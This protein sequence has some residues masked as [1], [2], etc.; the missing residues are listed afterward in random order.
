MSLKLAVLLADSNLDPNVASR[1]EVL[2]LAA[3]LEFWKDIV[4]EETGEVV[5]VPIDEITTKQSFK[6]QCDINKILERHSIK[7]VDSHQVIYPPE[8]Y[9]EFQNIDLVEAHAQ[10]GRAQGIFD[11]LP[12]EVR[13][14]FKNDALAFAAFA[15][16]P[17]N[18]DKLGELL[19]KIAEPGSYFPNPAQRGAQGAAAATAPLEKSGDA[20]A[21]AAS[22]SAQDGAQLAKASDSSSST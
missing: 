12:S 11:A 4:V 13:N 3:P 22:S 16:D 20:S 21:P 10:I 15:S 14:E 2:D 18:N 8:V 17:Q 19:P 5:K 6:D 7:A 1:D 9:H